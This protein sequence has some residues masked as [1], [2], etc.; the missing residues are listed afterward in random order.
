MRTQPRALPEVEH[1]RPG[2]AIR[3]FAL[4]GP[5]LHAQHFRLVSGRL[6]SKLSGMNGLE[7]TSPRLKSALVHERRSRRV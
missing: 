4:N 1:N 2:S 6:L 7:P 5:L 3:S